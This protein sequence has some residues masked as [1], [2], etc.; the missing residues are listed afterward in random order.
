MVFGIWMVTLVLGSS[1]EKYPGWSQLQGGARFCK[2]KSSSP[3]FAAPVSS[4]AAEVKGSEIL[5]PKAGYL[6]SI[7]SERLWMSLMGF[8]GSNYSNLGLIGFIVHLFLWAHG[9]PTFGLLGCPMLPY[10]FLI[11]HSVVYCWFSLP[12]DPRFRNLVDALEEGQP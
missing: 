4:K 6:T 2:A 9:Y 12:I 5:S 1:H 3:A 7:V 10:S 11:L 8:H